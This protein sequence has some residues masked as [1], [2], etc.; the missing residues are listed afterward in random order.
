MSITRVSHA[1]A[2]GGTLTLPSHQPGDL[3]IGVAWRHDGSTLGVYLSGGRTIRS[4]QALGY[5]MSVREKIATSSSE[6][7]GTSTDATQVGAIVYRHTNYLTGGSTNASNG[8]TDTLSYGVI[9]P[10]S[11]I[12]QNLDRWYVG[13]GAYRANNTSAIAAPTNMTTI[14]NIQGT[15]DGC[16]V[17]HDTNAL[18]SSAWS[19]QTVAG[20]SLQA[21]RTLVFEIFDTRVPVVAPTP[22][23]AKPTLRGGFAN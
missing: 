17:L 12:E 13:I 7:F 1:I 10:G 20:T 22:S 11:N 2:N 19:N 4:L 15:S 3:I 21:W 6:T 16:L 9:A 14:A 23:A 18:I 5:S 8:T